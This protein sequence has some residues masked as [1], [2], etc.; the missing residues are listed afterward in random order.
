MLCGAST[1]VTGPIGF[2]GLVVPHVC[3][4]LAGADYRWLI[5]FSALTG[6]LLLVAADVLGRIIA[7]PAELD[8]G[9]ITAFI[10]APLFIYIVRKKKTKAL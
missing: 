8:V 10:G 1:A 5:P 7:R 9:I 6:A 3:R 2:V 4:L